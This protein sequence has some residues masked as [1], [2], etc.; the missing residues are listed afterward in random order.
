MKKMFNN[1]ETDKDFMRERERSKS[2]F[3]STSVTIFDS[4]TVTLTKILLM[5]WERGERELVC[6]V[7]L[8]YFCTVYSALYS[9][10]VQ[11]LCNGAGC[12]AGAVVRCLAL[13]YCILLTNAVRSTV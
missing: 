7:L 9:A 5:M 13:A 8:L 11:S 10:N 12:W 4:V 6:L 1:L 3:F 2:L